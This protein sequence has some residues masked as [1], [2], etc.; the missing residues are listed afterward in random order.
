VLDPGSTATGAGIATLQA[1]I[2]ATPA[3]VRLATPRG[4]VDAGD[5]GIRSS[6]N[7]IIAATL[8]LNASNIQAQGTITGLPTISLPS[9]GTLTAA[10]NAA[11][12]ATKAVE[13]PAAAPA[14]QETPSIIT[15]EVLGY[16]GSSDQDKD[17]DKPN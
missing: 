17:R 5:A 6:R 15:V 8:V 14:Q 10:S 2:G 9:L 3:D 16:G 12:S 4:F 11:A 1:S 7:V 13:Q